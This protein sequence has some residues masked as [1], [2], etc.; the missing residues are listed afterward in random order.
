MKTSML[1]ALLMLCCAP[2][3]PLVG[4]AEKEGSP[5]TITAIGSGEESAYPDMAQ[6]KLAI[7]SEAASAAAAITD[8]DTV[9]N[10]LLRRL[11]DLGITKDDFQ[12]SRARVV[13]MFTQGIPG[14]QRPEVKGYQVTKYV[15][16]W[17]RRLDRLG[18][19]LDDLEAG[20]PDRIQDVRLA[21]GDP[22]AV[23]DKAR[24]KALSDARRRAEQLARESGMELGE[25]LDVRERSTGEPEAGEAENEQVFR[26]SVEVTFAAH[27]VRELHTNPAKPA[28]TS[29]DR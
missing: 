13:P 4:A 24:R 18:K 1:S 17:V 15:R 9:T 2:L 16:V 6:I 10:G 27:K 7:V 23:G 19:T 26:A 28:P 3:F 12:A 22:A 11:G 21:I 20:G 29:P 14:L 25:L 5:Q 8:N